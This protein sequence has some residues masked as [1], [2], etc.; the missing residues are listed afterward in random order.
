MI[1]TTLYFFHRNAILANVVLAIFL[2]AAPHTLTIFF[3]A[4]KAMVS[5]TVW[6]ELAEMCCFD[7]HRILRKILL[8]TLFTNIEITF[9]TA[10]KV[11]LFHLLWSVCNFKTTIA[12]DTPFRVLE[13]SPS[14]ILHH[15]ALRVFS[16]YSFDGFHGFLRFH[17]FDLLQNR[18]LFCYALKHCLLHLHQPPILAR[19]SC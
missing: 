10:K 4:E 19:S 13:N 7:A 5:F 16:Y 2:F 3:A 12:S 11:Q 14:K 8:P 6:L 15:V 17:R 18:H 1:I 9:L